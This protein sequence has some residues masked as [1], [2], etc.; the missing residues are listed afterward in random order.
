M[1]PGRAAA[2]VAAAALSTGFGA[3]PALFFNW[4]V[5]YPNVLGYA[6]VPAALAAVALVCRAP[7]GVE[8]IRASLL[9]LVTL[10]ACGLAHPNAALAAYAFGGAYAIGVLTVRAFEA[11]TR[12][13]WTTLAAAGGAIVV[14]FIAVWSVARTGAAHSA[15]VPWQSEAQ[16][17]GEALL[18]S[19]RG[20]TP[21]VI[22]VALVVV[23]LLAAALR[24]RKIPVILPFAV[25]VALFVLASGFRVDHWLRVWLTNPW[26]SDS[27]RL[28]ALLPIAAI[29]V[30]TLGVLAIVD[31]ARGIRVPER[32][33]APAT[34]VVAGFAGA[35]VL[36]TVGFGPNVRDA[37]FQVREAYAYTDDALLLSSDELSLI[38]RLPEQVPADATI[39]GSP[40]TGA[41]LAYALADRHVTELHIFGNRSEDEVFL[42]AN[43]GNID[44]DPAVC[45]AVERVGVDY[46]LDFGRRDVF[47]DDAAATVYDGVQDLASSPSLELVDSE[48]DDARLFR[49]VGC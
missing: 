29:P 6:V 25:A 36:F 48:G 40:R 43:L 31:R 39:I 10:A 46:V 38:R 30:A 41:S 26:Y 49:I 12:A 19:P 23:G 47:G 5:L 35:A 18:V 1:F 22:A 15:W 34:R 14:I 21:T 44:S 2:F 37:L 33:N 17:L 9:L 13:A 3:F 16:A 20:F 42:D 32:W 24:P 28:A 27:N 11:R 45:S 4:G 7:R 8:L